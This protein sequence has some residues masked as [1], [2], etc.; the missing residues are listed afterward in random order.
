MGDAPID[1]LVASIFADLRAAHGPDVRTGP[2]E[3]RTVSPQLLAAA[4]ANVKAARL[5]A[6]IAAAR[7]L[8]ATVRSERDELS[9]A[10]DWATEKLETTLAAADGAV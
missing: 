5:S 4:R 9:S 3:L 10:V 6:V 2:G 8:V 1:P 7:A